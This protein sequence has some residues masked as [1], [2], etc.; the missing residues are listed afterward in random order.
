MTLLSNN[1]LSNLFKYCKMERVPLVKKID[2]IGIAVHSIEK[3]LPFYTD[4]LNLTLLGIEEVDSEKVKV[5]FLKIGESKFELLEPTSSESAIAMFLEKRGEGIH[6]VALA[7]D[8][9][10]D[11][12]KEIKEKGIRMINETPKQGAGGAM[13]AFMHPKSTGGVLVEYCEKRGMNN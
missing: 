7:V 1:I 13:V 8:S 9:I 11:R 3:A 5:A 4:V 2:H 12:I 6:H 10:E